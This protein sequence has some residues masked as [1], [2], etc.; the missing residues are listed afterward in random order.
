MLIAAVVGVVLGLVAGSVG[1]RLDAL[2]MRVADVQ[3]AFPVIMLAIVAVVG[4]ILWRWSACS[5]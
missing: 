1:G 5:R 2:V 4:T 3:L